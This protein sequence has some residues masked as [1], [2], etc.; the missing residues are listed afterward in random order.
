M[1]RLALRL[2]FAL[3]VA[4]LFFAV[5]AQACPPD[6]PFCDRCIEI[7]D[8]SNCSASCK[9]G[10][11]TTTCGQWDGNPAN[12][13]DGDGVVNASD[14]CMCTPNSNQADCDTDG[15]GDA[16]D[17]VNE[18]WTAISTTFNA[19]AWDSDEHLTGFGVEIYNATTYRNVCNNATCVKKNLIDDGFCCYL[20]DGGSGG[21]DCCRKSFNNNSVCGQ[22]PHDQCGSPACPF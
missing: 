8:G 13:L 22:F 11:V 5:A 14:N 18:K 10:G 21:A 4:L 2:V 20:C 9:A 3:P 12:D 7:C 16:C 17:A 15:I 19:C 6:D 1:Q